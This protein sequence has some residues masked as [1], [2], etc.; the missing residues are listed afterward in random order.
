M[1]IKLLSLNSN[2][3]CFEIIIYGMP[4]IIKK[5]LNSNMRCFEIIDESQLGISLP[6]KH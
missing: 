4:D 5:W 3:R 6:V 1:P 2:M